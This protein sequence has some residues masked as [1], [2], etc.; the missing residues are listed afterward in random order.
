MGLTSDDPEIRMQ[1][2]RELGGSGR[3]DAVDAL[4]KMTEIDPD[5]NV[6]RIARYALRQLESDIASEDRMERV[7]TLDPT[8]EEAPTRRSQR[9]L[10]RERERL[11]RRVPDRPKQNALAWGMERY[12]QFQN[13]ENDNNVAKAWLY[14]FLL[15]FSSIIGPTLFFGFIYLIVLLVSGFDGRVL[16]IGAALPIIVIVSFVYLFIVNVVASIVSHGVALLLG[17]RATWAASINGIAPISLVF[18]LGFMLS[19]MVEGQ[20]PRAVREQVGN[21]L[22]TAVGVS[23]VAFIIRKLTK[24][25][26]FSYVQATLAYGITGARDYR[27]IFCICAARVG[28]G[29]CIWY[30]GGLYLGAVMPVI[31]IKRSIFRAA[32]T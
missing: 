19:D 15:A 21:V 29:G 26:N 1:T 13:S 4:R 23:Q 11:A 9:R 10:N 12:R 18:S 7:H 5:P 31:C 24:I 20:M 2:I 6:R 32:S 14:L 3:R 28:A 17:G 25:Y 22:D 27:I 30:S 8:H 16:A